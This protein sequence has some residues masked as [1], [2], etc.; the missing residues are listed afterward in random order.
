[1]SC[2]YCAHCAGVFDLSK[3]CQGMGFPIF[4]VKVLPVFLYISSTRYSMA[5]FTFFTQRSLKLLSR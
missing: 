2:T 5:M 4:T 3:V 1:M